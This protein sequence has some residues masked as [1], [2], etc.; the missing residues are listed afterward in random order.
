[1]S[2]VPQY[3]TKK[4]LVTL[5]KMILKLKKGIAKMF[6]AYKEDEEDK[7]MKGKKKKKR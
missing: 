6:K 4:E 1:M 5:T 7:K 2:R 3:A